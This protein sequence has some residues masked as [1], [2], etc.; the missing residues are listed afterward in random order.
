MFLDSLPILDANN[1]PT[2]SVLT[3]IMLL[4]TGKGIHSIHSLENRELASPLQ[5]QRVFCII[6]G[7]SE[8][9]QDPLRT[10]NKKRTK[11]RTLLTSTVRRVV[12][13]KVAD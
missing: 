6:P 4:N 10:C 9:I 2:S 5:W 8:D 1:V 3:V 12:V 7:A 11:I 13:Y